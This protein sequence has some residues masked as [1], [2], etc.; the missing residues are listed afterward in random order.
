[1]EIPSPKA[2]LL[3][4]LLVQNPPD[5]LSKAAIHEKIWPNSFVSEATLASLI[6]EIR[7]AI[8][9][10]AGGAHSIR[11]VHGFGYAF[12]GS[13]A[14]AAPSHPAARESAW[15]LFWD[16]RK[17]LLPQGET[18]VGRDHLA[19]VCIPSESVPRRHA[20]LIVTGDTASVED[21]DSK[22]GTYVKGEK[23]G[24]RKKLEDRDSIRIGPATLIIRSVSDSQ[25]TKTEIDAP[26]IEEP[27]LPEPPR[28]KDRRRAP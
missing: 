12:A 14:E 23:I 22:N 19:G 3:L 25:S 2:F 10:G 6:A 4:E 8:G 15:S 27:A 21:L 28:R 13:A 11:T 26:A 16:D 17:I 5:A 9:E 20:R 18:I 24:K 1:M 7:Q